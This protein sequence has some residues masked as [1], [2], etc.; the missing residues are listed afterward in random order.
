MA[1]RIGLIALLLAVAAAGWWLSNRPPAL[2]VDDFLQQHWQY[3][4]AAQGQPPVQFSALEASLNPAD[5]G[6]CHAAQFEQW[7]SSLH[8][9]TMGPGILWQ[10]HFTDLKNTKACLRCHAPM[11]EQ[12]ALQAQ[13]RGWSDPNLA[14]PA[15][16]PPDL[17]AQ[18]LV[19]AACHVR[20]H[21]RFG[22]KASAPPA[23]ASAHGGFV[24][25]EAFADSRFCANC[26]QFAEDGPRLNGKLREDT[27]NQWRA[28]RFAIEG[29]HCQNCHMPQRQHLWRG[30]HDPAMTASAL[31]VEIVW[32]EENGRLVGASAAVSNSG[33]GH[34]FPT[35]LVP[36]VVLHLE[37]VDAAGAV[38]ELAQEVIGWKANLALTEE[39]FDTRLAAGEARSLSGRHDNLEPSGKIRLR[40]QVAP[41][42]Q[43]RLTFES[44]LA[45][46]GNK[47]KPVVRELL[48]QAIAE[49]R[50]AEYEFIA[51]ERPLPGIAN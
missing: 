50:A 41:R 48:Q 7:R 25:H 46:S 21:T 36:E 45:G 27:Y 23:T 8:S 19:C 24:E 28:T 2:S 15:Y 47:L 13:A 26:H 43:Y 44:Y 42:Q 10:L 37:Y 11:T 32:L 30:I 29:K 38:T 35:Y 22:P 51:G 12:L 4:I 40:I 6:S 20:A 17:H 1:K 49:A 39:I 5:C 33:A 14:P 31:S 16:V 9:H 18:G 34:D 3:P